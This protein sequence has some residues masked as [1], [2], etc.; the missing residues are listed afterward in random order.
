MLRLTRR[1]WLFAVAVLAAASAASLALLS[2]GKVLPSVVRDPIYAFVQPGVAV[3]W[4]LFAGL[5]QT[6]PTSATGIA[7]GLRKRRAVVAGAMARH[8]DFACCWSNS[9][10]IALM[11]DMSCRLKN[12]WGAR[13][14]DKVPGPCISARGA[15]INR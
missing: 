7:F 3:W 6:A 10:E 11:S 4:F 5:F 9:R 14:E 13:A 12:R 8:C 1:W 2:S 15:Q